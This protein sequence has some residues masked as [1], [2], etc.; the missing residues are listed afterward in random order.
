[1]YLSLSRNLKRNLKYHLSVNVQLI[2]HQ[3]YDYSTVSDYRFITFVKSPG[4]AQLTAA[5][6]MIILQD[7]VNV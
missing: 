4:F 5:H 2:F 3:S 1:M 6:G 7:H